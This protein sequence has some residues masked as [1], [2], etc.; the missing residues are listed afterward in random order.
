MDK[1]VD[2]KTFTQI[3]CE[4]VRLKALFA[5]MSE[6]LP[7]YPSIAWGNYADLEGNIR[8]IIWEK[9]GLILLIV[10]AARRA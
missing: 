10:L 3:M 7:L 8:A 1:V 5:R 9:V 2:L 4:V 6:D